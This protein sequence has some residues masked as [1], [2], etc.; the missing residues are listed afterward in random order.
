MGSES[1]FDLLGSE[2]SPLGLEDFLT[3]TETSDSSK[4]EE[5]DIYFCR[6]LCFLLSECFLDLGF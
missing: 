2:E 6:D 3:C 5:E 4:E 1:S